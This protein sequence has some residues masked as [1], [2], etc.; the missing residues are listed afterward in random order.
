[1]KKCYNS[2]DSDLEIV[3]KG[4]GMKIADYLR[5]EGFNQALALADVWKKEE[6]EKGIERGIER[7]IE[8]GVHDGFAK[9]ADVGF[10]QAIKTVAMTMLGNGLTV[11]DVSRYTGLSESQIQELKIPIH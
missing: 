7:G 2:I 4:N 6:F 5:Q 11:S 3:E 9:G 8:Q 10:S 1:M